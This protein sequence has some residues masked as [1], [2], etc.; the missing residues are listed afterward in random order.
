MDDELYTDEQIEEMMKLLEDGTTK[1]GLA[2][3]FRKRGWKMGMEL[4]YDDVKY[5]RGWGLQNLQDAQEA[6]ILHLGDNT[7]RSVQDTR[8]SLMHSAADAAIG[9]ARQGILDRA[10]RELEDEVK[11]LIDERSDADR[12]QQDREQDEE[13]QEK[14]AEEKEEQ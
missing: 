13:E 3:E 5:A 12:I 9:E 4:N 1:P 11:K 7:A 2:E 6:E 10:S 8:K 14:E